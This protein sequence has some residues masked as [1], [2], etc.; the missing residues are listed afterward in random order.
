MPDALDIILRDLQRMSAGAAVGA[1]DEVNAT[2]LKRQEFGTPTIPPRPTLTA[3]T[4]RAERPIFDAV[5]RKVRAVLDG[6]SRA[7]E[8]IVQDVG[9]DLAEQVRDE[10]ANNVQP[11]LAESTKAS[12]RRRGKD[13]RTLVDSGD[14]KASIRVETRADEDQ[15]PNED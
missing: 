2:K 1:H 7:G 12:R 5:A 4:D 14:M 6:K 8:A 13:D 9:A 10:I 11:P 3:A 15:W